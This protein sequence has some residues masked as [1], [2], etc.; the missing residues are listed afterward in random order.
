MRITKQMKLETICLGLISAFT[1]LF[2]KTAYLV[3][4]FLVAALQIFFLIACTKAPDLPS[5]KVIWYSVLWYTFFTT[6]PGAIT[7]YGY[8]F[9][10]NYRG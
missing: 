10:L 7:M 2:C 4:I 1:G 6:V 8:Q 5:K 3:I 9:L